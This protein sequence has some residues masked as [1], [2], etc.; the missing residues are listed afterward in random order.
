M[1]SAHSEIHPSGILPRLLLLLC[2]LST[3]LQ[4]ERQ[5]LKLL[6]IGNSFAEN[7]LVYLPEL[8]NAGGKSL[9][10]GRANTPGC[11]LDKHVAAL[12]IL[13]RDPCD[14]K[15]RPYSNHPGMPETGP[16]YNLVEL[17][18]SESWDAVTLQQ[19]STRSFVAESF[20]PYAERLVGTIRKH[21]PKARLWAF[22]PWAY[23]EDSPLFHPGKGLT[24]EK[25]FDGIRECY[26]TLARELDLGLVP[27]GEAFQAARRSSAWHF[28]AGTAFDPAQLTPPALPD[29]TGSLNVGWHWTEDSPPRLQLDA[30]HANT[31]GKYLAAVVLYLSLF[32]CAHAPSQYQPPGLT[33]EQTRSLRTIAETCMEAQPHLNNQHTSP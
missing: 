12:E 9:L 8:A 25:M 19:V 33:P 6:T 21:A 24:Q 17:L 28:N 2:A 29:Q 23:R 5:S 32:E 14:P 16:H 3:C 20:H 13:D 11:S 4:A 22:E 15:G 27:V 26:H 30:N 1:R 31:A 7:A 18:T 10:I